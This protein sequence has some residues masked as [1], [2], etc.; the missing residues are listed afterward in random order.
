[1]WT[2]NYCNCCIKF[3]K[4]LRGTC[5]YMTFCGLSIIDDD[6]EVVSTRTNF[7]KIGTPNMGTGQ[8]L[9]CRCAQPAVFSDRAGY[10]STHTVAKY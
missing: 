10:T 3:M 8:F 1:M 7:N 6:Y 5:F 2:H 4:S 9:L